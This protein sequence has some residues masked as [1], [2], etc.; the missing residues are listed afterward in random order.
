MAMLKRLS[1]GGKLA[2]IICVISAVAVGITAVLLFEL[3]G[4]ML[5]GRKLKLRALVESAVNIIDSYSQQAEDGTLNEEDAKQQ[6]LAAIAAMNFDG[7]NYFFIA[8]TEGVL[9]WH[10]SRQEQ[11]G[12][13]LLEAKSAQT[14]ANYSGFLSAAK[15]ADY[16]E[17]YSNSL[18]RRPG[19]KELNAAKM[20]L[21]VTDKHWNWVITTGLFIDDI[22]ATFYK[23]AALF[24]GLAAA[25]L[26]FG[27]G[28]S[29]VVGRSITRPVNRTV[30]AL[31][32]LS[33]GRTDTEVEIDNS[34]TEVGRLTRAFSHFREKML[35]SEELRRQ[36][37]I[38][39]QLAERERHEALLGFADEFER[40]VGSAVTFMNEEVRKVSDA[41]AEMSKSA[42]ASASGTQQVNAAAESTARNVQ[43]VASAAQELTASISEIQ[44]QVS[45][46]QNVVENTR[47][48]SDQTED[49][50]SALAGTVEKIGSVVELINSIAEQTN[51][52]ALNATI[53]AARAGD[54]GK[55]FAV[56]A[57][58]V[59][60][61]ATQ[62]KQA[63]EDI[64][65]Q[66]TVLNEATGQCVGSI[67]D[68]ASS[69]DE[70]LNTTTAIAAAIE[71]QN[72]ATA[73]IGRNTDITAEE[74]HSITQA[75]GDVSASVQITETTAQ[76]VSQTSAL[77]RE[78]A[79]TVSREVQNFLQRVRTG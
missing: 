28:L 16:L 3:K 32:D 48:R 43:T 13:N 6:A 37:A 12:L 33:E 67:K 23:R 24:L 44:R 57:G 59:K 19:S 7:K 50:M 45:T 47:T 17:G 68:V 31:E 71:E 25:G 2:L 66:I 72:A 8:N 46:V 22:E 38:A 30:G 21:S 26:L 14:R 62:T 73:E 49:Q 42:Q 61:L 75:I 79:D 63:T 64:R 18:G 11:I 40:S 60:V 15:N 65:E 39:E 20:Y 41:S 54:A 35:E 56:V 5:E 52:L 27:L 36:Q 9:V 70:L 77:M 1:I 10:P 51:L 4:T 74:T 29:Y 76:S 58:E 53:E 69:V 55:G 78:K 34:A